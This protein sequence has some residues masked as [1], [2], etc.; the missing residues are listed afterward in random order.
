MTNDEI[1]MTKRNSNTP[2][3]LSIRICFV[4]RASS[5][6]IHIAFVALLAFQFFYVFVRLAGIHAAV[7]LND[8][9]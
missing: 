7:F 5:F 2:R 3:Y 8:F 1:R 4:I 6:L 9:A